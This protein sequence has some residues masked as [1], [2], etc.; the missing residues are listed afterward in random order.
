MV[1]AGGQGSNGVA[2]QGQ[3]EGESNTTIFVGGLDSDVTDEDLRQP[4][5][6]FGEVVSVKIPPGKA[7]GFVQFAN[8]KDA[9]SAIHT[10]N[11][12][13]IGKQ[14]VRL[15]WGRTPGHRHWRGDLSNQ[16]NGVHHGGQGGYGGGY[17]YAVAQHTAATVANEALD[18]GASSEEGWL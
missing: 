8:R 9:E 1:L 12:T 6:Q 18:R 17:G 13:V 2:G 4:F 16:W 10:L 7:C 15:S 14:T 3:S 11:G 5:S